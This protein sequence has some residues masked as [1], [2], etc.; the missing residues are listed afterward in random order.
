MIAKAGNNPND[1]SYRPISLLR[2]LSKILEKI[3]PKRLT[4]IIDESKLIT[5]QQF[6]VRKEHGTT[7][8]A[9]RLVYKINNALESKRYCSVAFIDISQAFDKIWHTGLP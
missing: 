1:I 8:Q 3:L 6:G 2:V 9:Y 4:P 7:Q 5:S